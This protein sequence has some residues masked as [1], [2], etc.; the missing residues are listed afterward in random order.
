MRP[1][2][3]GSSTTG[4]KKSVVATSAWVSL[5]RQTAASSEVSVPTIRSAKAAVAGMPFRMSCRTAGASLQPQPPPW[6]RL[7]RRT[8][9]FGGLGPVSGSAT[10]IRRLIERTSASAEGRTALPIEHLKTADLGSLAGFDAVIDVRSPSEFAEDHA[11]GA[12]NLPVLSD[13]QRA[14]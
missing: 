3:N 12:I 13:D 2:S 11:P 9:P 8:S 14:M 5:S 6:A 10:L 1:K 7:V 4:M